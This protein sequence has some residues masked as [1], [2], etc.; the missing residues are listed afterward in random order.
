MLD[1]KQ[2]SHKQR[3][4]FSIGIYTLRKNSSLSLSTKSLIPEVK[5]CARVAII[6]KLCDEVGCHSQQLYLDQLIICTFLFDATASVQIQKTQ[7]VKERH[8]WRFLSIS[9]MM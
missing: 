4:T 1:G 3:V 7:P 9:R 8:R 6:K 2:P 5:A